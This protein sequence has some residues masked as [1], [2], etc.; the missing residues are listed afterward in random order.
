MHLLDRLLHG[1][2]VGRGGDPG[3][4]DLVGGPLQAALQHPPLGL[5]RRV[6]DGQPQQEPVELGLG[7]RVGALELDR[8][9]VAT[10][11][12]G[13]SRDRVTPSM[14]TCRSCIASSRAAWVLGGDRLISSPS[15]RLVNTGPGR[16]SKSPERW[17]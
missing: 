1:Q 4:L 6:A 2:H 8:F 13:R 5:G 12:N 16:N 11:R 3:Q 9:W 7:Q 17:L 10:T 14:V 15:S